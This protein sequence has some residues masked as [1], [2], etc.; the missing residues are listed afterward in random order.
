MVARQPDDLWEIE[1]HHLIPQGRFGWGRYQ[2]N[3]NIIHRCTVIRLT[4]HSLVFCAIYE[5]AYDLLYRWMPTVAY[6]VSLFKMVAKE[7]N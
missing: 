5:V 6:I 4:S 7:Q 1:Q 2:Q 3:Y